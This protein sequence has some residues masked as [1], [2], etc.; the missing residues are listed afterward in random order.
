[1][2]RRHRKPPRP[3]LPVHVA[4]TAVEATRCW[5]PQTRAS[6]SAGCQGRCRSPTPPTSPSKHII[7]AFHA[8][9][10]PSLQ[11]DKAA[12]AC[13]R[14]CYRRW[15]I[16]FPSPKHVHFRCRKPPRLLSP[17]HAATI[18]VESTCSCH[19]QTRVAIAAGRWG[20]CCR[21]NECRRHLPPPTACTR[22]CHRR[23]ALAVN[24]FGTDRRRCPRTR[25]AIAE[26]RQGCCCRSHLP[27]AACA[28]HRFVAHNAT[29]IE[30]YFR[31]PRTY[32]A[33][34]EIRQGPTTNS[35][36]TKNIFWRL[37]NNPHGRERPYAKARSHLE[38]APRGL[39]SLQNGRLQHLC[40]HPCR[41]R[42]S[43]VSGAAPPYH[44][45]YHRPPRHAYWL[46]QGPLH[47]PAFHQCRQLTVD[48]PE[49]LRRRLEHAC[50]YKHALGWPTKVKSHKPP[51]L[52][53]H[54]R[55]HFHKSRLRLVGIIWWNA[56]MGMQDQSRQNLARVGTII[57]K[58]I[59]SPEACLPSLGLSLEIRQ[60]QCCN[61]SAILRRHITHGP[62]QV[63]TFRGAR[64]IWPSQYLPRQPH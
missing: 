34:V 32:A 3:L 6:I 25:A 8:R 45:L 9:V 46:S 11:A 53:C 18:V 52:Q 2:C 5:R 37:S 63:T 57:Q 33:V 28:C 39:H 40:I 43:L 31:C 60:R 19:P 54:P 64:W 23:A 56:Q 29:D 1:M 27:P 35:R 44:L 13:T 14:R 21:R 48:H 12:A 41:R 50:L 7:S 38:D 20:H 47:R 24:D 51:P 42:L 22:R 36:R 61:A 59:R 58:D 62:L 10:P 4:A 30:A 15:V 17:A 49:L 55:I 26:N 16:S